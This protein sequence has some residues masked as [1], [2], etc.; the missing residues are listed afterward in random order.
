MPRN[1]N[2]YIIIKLLYVEKQPLL[3]GCCVM[4]STVTSVA[5]VVVAFQAVLHENIG[6]LEQQHRL[7][8]QRV[9]PSMT[10]NFE[11]FEFC[12]IKFGGGARISEA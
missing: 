7:Y 12:N 3:F 6:I 8:V 1:T 9:D 11:H 4:A 5:S 10:Y 2:I